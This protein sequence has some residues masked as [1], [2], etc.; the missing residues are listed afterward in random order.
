MSQTPH[1]AI[2]ESTIP[3]LQDSQTTGVQAHE[4]Q[5]QPPKEFFYL[6]ILLWAY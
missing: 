6:L 5:Q 3:L 4:L 1:L 2:S